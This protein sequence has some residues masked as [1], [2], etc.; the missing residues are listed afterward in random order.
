MKPFTSPVA[1][2]LLD[3]AK[4]NGS[5]G[6]SGDTLLNNNRLPLIYQP[7]TLNGAYLGRLPPLVSR[8]DFRRK[9]FMFL[10]SIFGLG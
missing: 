2:P 3:P 6:A 7:H 10:A 8:S 1:Q 4:T 9:P 5:H